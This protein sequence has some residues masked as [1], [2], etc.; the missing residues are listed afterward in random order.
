MWCLVITWLSL[1]ITASYSQSVPVPQTSNIDPFSNYSCDPNAC[2][3]PA[4]KCATRDPPTPNPPQ[5][6]TLTFDDS[7]QQSVLP[8]ALDLFQNRKNPN[9][10]PAKATWFT[11]VYYSDPFLVTQWYAQG[12]EM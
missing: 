9:G 5:F 8:Q 11:Q 7:L 10:C 1:L 12:N 2:K 3:L 6:L 4:C